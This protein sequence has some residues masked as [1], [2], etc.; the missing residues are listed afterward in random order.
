MSAD[1]KTRMG[2]RASQLDGREPPHRNN[3]RHGNG[4]G[5]LSLASTVLPDRTVGSVR[6]KS[7]MA[8]DVDVDVKDEPWMS[9]TGS[10][11]SG[12]TS[13]TEKSTPCP[14][15]LPPPRTMDGARKLLTRLVP[16]FRKRDLEVQGLVTG[17]GGECGPYGYKMYCDG[18]LVFELR[19][20]EDELI[21]LDRAMSNAVGWRENSPVVVSQK[22][23]GDVFGVLDGYRK[24]IEDIAE[25]C[26]RMR[27]MQ[28]GERLPE[29]SD[30]KWL[31]ENVTP[32]AVK[33]A[34][35][36]KHLKSRSQV[37]RFDI[38][39]ENSGF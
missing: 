33:H 32:E 22:L 3:T 12:S 35:R 24:V 6:N 13:P 14:T 15:E 4:S 18:H 23:L 25:L 2:N 36:L 34:E 31:K 28:T 21:D 8:L 7:R 37:V 16:V 10:D 5:S 38:E 11:F 1:S 39:Q 26:G 9:E 30:L 19:M 27:G 29:P 17:L 20:T